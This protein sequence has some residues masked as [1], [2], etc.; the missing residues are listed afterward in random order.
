M[1]TKQTGKLRVVQEDTKVKAGAFMSKK[2]R[3][4][5][6]H[7]GA[8]SG[9]ATSLAFTPVQGIELGDPEAERKRREAAAGVKKAGGGWFSG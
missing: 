1:S 6:A 7:T 3:G 5:L 9:L 4:V 8:V 2:M